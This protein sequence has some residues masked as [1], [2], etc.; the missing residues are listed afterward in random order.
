ML[1]ILRGVGKQPLEPALLQWVD[2]LRPH[3]AEAMAIYRHLSELHMQSVAGQTILD[4]LRH[5][6]LLVDTARTLR[7]ANA[8][9]RTALA[10]ELALRVVDQ[11]VRGSNPSDD[12]ALAKALDSLVVAAPHMDMPERLFVRLRGT[13]WQQRFGVSLSALRPAETG[14][15]FGQMPL[16]MLV[17]HDGNMETECDPFLLQELFGLTPAEADVGVLLSQGATLEQ[18]AGRR[19]VS[20]ATVRSQLRGLMDKTGTKRQGDLVR[21]LLTLPHGFDGR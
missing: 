9:G 7:F 14:G 4:R 16:A 8:A 20:I 17:L 1:C 13:D 5:P 6:V 19:H 10:S 11:Q 12:R 21:R 2:G 3:L 15:A 18:I